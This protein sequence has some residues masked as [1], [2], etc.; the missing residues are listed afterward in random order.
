MR[1][2]ERDTMFARM[3]YEKGTDAYKDYYKNNPDK[4]EV[5]DALRDMPNLCSPGTVTY[6][7]IASP[8]VSST[9]DFL[10][11]LHPLCE[12]DVA[13]EKIE[14]DP[15][16][17]ATRLKG[18][19]SY[20][21]AKLVGITEIKDSHYYSHRGRKPE[22]Y[23]D[24]VDYPHKYGF[25]FAV[26][27]EQDSIYRAPQLS[28]SLAS[29]KGYMDGAIIGMIIS[30]YIRSLGYDAR[31][32]MDGN[33]LGV[34]PL[35]AEDA[36]LGQVARN[37]LLL[38]KKYGSRVRLGM[39]TTDME[40]PLDSPDDFGL[41]TFC[42]ECNICS[43]TCP[44]KSISKSSEPDNYNGK[45]GFKINAEECYK[46]WRSLGTDCGI[47][48]ANCPFSDHV[49]AELVAKMKDSREVRQQIIDE[50]KEKFPIRPYIRG[51]KEWL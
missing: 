32:H 7:A 37:G 43:R 50:F 21:G 27:M 9:F 16:E 15:N 4:K 5:D 41:I 39:V 6:D 20:Y 19:A 36:G 51:N 26:E 3:A 28:V 23:G 35:I 40:L 11:H 31:N 34:L 38:T 10:S 18:L 2:D 45:L 25:I 46:R 12:G 14:Y 22:N 47:C 29:T 30:Y 44:G 42:S 49:D 17:M 24:S 1:Y 13:P 8:I 48:L 33:Y